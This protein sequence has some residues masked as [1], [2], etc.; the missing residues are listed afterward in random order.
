VVDKHSGSRA[1]EMK[2]K[3]FGEPISED[4]ACG[5]LPLVRQ[6]AIELKRSLTDD[7]LR[8]LRQ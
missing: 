3:A 2:F 1:L 6:R 8:A 4:E 7:E 5:L